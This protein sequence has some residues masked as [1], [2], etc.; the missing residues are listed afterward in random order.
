MNKYTLIAL[1]FILAS[2][3]S[4]I[5][6]TSLDDKSLNTAL[7][8][9]VTIKGKAVDAKL[10]A[11]LMK[12]DGS[13]IWINNLDS[14]PEVFYNRGDEGKVIEVTGKIIEK[15]DLPVFISKEGDPPRSGIPVPKGTDLKKAS[16]RYLIDDAKWKII[17]D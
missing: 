9:N 15:Y 3:S 5:S 13:T 16:H 8:K 7:G 1:V 10:G 4:S 17:R 2:C 6:L 12:D 14:W 11:L